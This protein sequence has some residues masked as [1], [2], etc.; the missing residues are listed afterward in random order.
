MIKRTAKP[1]T[2]PSIENELKLENPA[3]FKQHERNIMIVPVLRSFCLN[4]ETNPIVKINEAK[5]II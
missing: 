3:K 1:I 2:C 4:I 5:N